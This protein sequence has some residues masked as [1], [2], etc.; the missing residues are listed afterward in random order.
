MP[1]RRPAELRA[2]TRY[3]PFVRTEPGLPRGSTALA[4]AVL[5][6]ELEH[7][8]PGETA[9]AL[10]RWARQVRGPWRSLFYNDDCPCDG[11]VR[12]DPRLVL[13]YALCA[14]PQ[15]RARELRAFVQLLDEIYLSRTW[16]DPSAP[17]DEP[18]WRR[19][20]ED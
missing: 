3:F 2:A 14:L 5:C 15:R 13:E 4:A 6:W 9:R 8:W 20:C 16:A 10:R 19:R 1:R 7:A 12:D 11:C 18:W 17:S